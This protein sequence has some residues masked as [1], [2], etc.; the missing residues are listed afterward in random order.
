M[1]NQTRLIRSVALLLAAGSA[2][3]IA[4]PGVPAQAASAPEFHYR[5][6]FQGP[7]GVQL[8]SVRNFIPK[9][10]ARTLARVR[11]LGFRNVE[12]AGTYGM[13][14]AR[15]RQE[16]DRAGLRAVSMHVIYNTIRDSTAAVLDQ[17][18]T[19]GVQYVGVA[20]IPYRGT[21]TAEMARASAA[22]FNR[23]GRAARAQGLQFF[24][25]THGFEFQPTPDGGTVFDVLM[26]ETDPALVQFQMDVMW[27][28]MPGQDP[29]ALLRKYPDRWRSMHMKDMK[30][31]TATGLTARLGPTDE[32]PVG[33]GAIDFPGLLAVAREI[34]VRNYFIEDETAEPFEGMPRS[35]DFLESVKFPA[36]GQ[37]RAATQNAPALDIY[38]IDTE[39]GQSTLFVAPSGQTVLID[40]GNPGSRDLDRIMSVIEQA[41]VKQ[42]DF[43]LLTHY[44]RDHV[45]NVEALASRIPIR[46]FVDH[47]AT[48][49]PREAVPGFQAAYAHLY[50]AAARTVARPGDSLPV[51]GLDWRIVSSAGE[52]LRT[53][54]AGGGAPN[55]ACSTFQPKEI[56]TDL[57]NG[58]SVGSVISY[59]RFRAVDLGDLLWNHEFD[60]MCPRNPIGQVDLYIVSHHG[61]D[62]SGSAALV[63]GLAPRVAIM[64]NGIRKGGSLS[65]FATI[66]TSPGL[67]DLWQLHWSANGGVE[68]NGPGLFIAN[69]ADST[70]TGP[71]NAHEGP[72]SYIKVSAHADGS[73]TVTNSRNGFTKR[74]GAE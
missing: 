4:P 66:H 26:R 38:L 59:G 32:V 43:L 23:W 24:Y 31:G 9:D 3:L 7:L 52:V 50:G 70:A 35:I 6:D 12:L 62:Q 39:G 36:T 65:T 54:L 33:S 56:T 37:A 18:K 58:Q 55:A 47:G 74:Y 46:H 30:R 28:A 53:P 67:E 45:G 44:H 27:V 40:T 41:G 8:Y 49:E 15:F 2:A 61:S 69:V 1:V 51:A 42:L 68:Q 34:G 22:D 14:A 11:R 71:G 21:F 29:V 19:L 10:P 48:V 63:H 73:F 60:L 5:G 20:N 25:H 64:N 16:L 57:D 17:A 13:T 72:A